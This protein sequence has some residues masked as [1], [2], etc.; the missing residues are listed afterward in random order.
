[1]TDIKLLLELSRSNSTLCPLQHNTVLRRR[2][3]VA[4]GHYPTAYLYDLL[5]AAHRLLGPIW[6]VSNRSSSRDLRVYKI[7]ASYL[8]TVAQ[9]LNAVDDQGE[10][11][12]ATSRTVLGNVLQLAQKFA[13]G[14]EVRL[15]EREATLLLNAAKLAANVSTANV[16]SRFDLLLGFLTSNFDPLGLFFDKIG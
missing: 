1:V 9:E 12:E 13:N 14:S 11:A 5:R 6:H 10:V 3:K 15:C 16:N 8:I 7:A 2:I 4:Y